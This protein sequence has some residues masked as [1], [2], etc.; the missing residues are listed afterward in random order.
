MKAIVSVFVE[1]NIDHC[2]E[3]RETDKNIGKNIWQNLMKVRNL[4]RASNILQDS[5]IFC[6]QQKQ[7]RKNNLRMIEKYFGNDILLHI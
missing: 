1:M 7:K 5:I 3:L 6:M 2:I 4:S